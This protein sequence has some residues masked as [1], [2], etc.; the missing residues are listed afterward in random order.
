MLHSNLRG[1]RRAKQLEGRGAKEKQP[2]D[3]PLETAR[4]RS[5]G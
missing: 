5:Y 4:E 1:L 3:S 2:R